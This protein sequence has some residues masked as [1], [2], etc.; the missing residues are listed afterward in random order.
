VSSS[1]PDLSEPGESIPPRRGTTLYLEAYSLVFCLAGT[2]VFFSFY[3]PTK[4]TFPT[5][6]NMQAIL[7]GQAVIAVVALAALIPLIAN[8]F[9]LSIGAV[10]GLSA[11]YSASAL[12]DGAPVLVGILL[13]VGLGAI[14]GL[15]NG[16][17]ITR[18]GVSSVIT[19]LGTATIVSGVIERKTG[20]LPVV[21]EIPAQVTSFGSELTLGIPNLT[22]AMA[23][24][25]AGVFYVMAY[26]PPGRNLYGIGSNPVAARLVGVNVPRYVL[27]SF[28]GAGTL[29]G[30]AGVLQ[31]S[32]AGGAAPRV[33]E[34]FTLPALAAA[35][36]SAV[37]IIPGRYNVAGVLIAIF[38]LATLNSGLNLAG[39]P[40]YVG[41]CVNGVA[42][43]VG[44]G[45]G[46]YF[47]RATR[48]AV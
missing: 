22:Y 12:T 25:A 46:R 32:Y 14:V 17:L 5:V 20:G 3:G 9:D 39:T 28:V 47:G 37:S 36:L 24:V 6:A 19:T 15:A 10:A 13:G 43:I 1:V 16:L 48:G 31:V 4:A 30:I 38:F 29:A 45:L 23:G 33:G 27:L 18:I 11:V 44:V 7:A 8:E 34:T 26:T 35:F 21:G 42:L 2:I 40:P 41:Q